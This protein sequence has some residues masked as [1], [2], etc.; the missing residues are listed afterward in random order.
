MLLLGAAAACSSDSGTKP[1]DYTSLAQLNAIWSV[2]G[3]LSFLCNGSPVNEDVTGT[4]IHVFN[5]AFNAVVVLPVATCGSDAIKFQGTIDLSGAITGNVST[6]G[7]SPLVDTFTGSCTS[8]SC[9]GATS[10]TALFSFTLSNT[11][12]DVYDG[13]SWQLGITCSDGS[14]MK[15]MPAVASIANAGVLQDSAK[16]CAGPICT[17]TGSTAGSG[18]TV[19][20]TGTVANDGTLSASFMQSAAETLTFAGATNTSYTSLAGTGT[21]G[22]AISLTQC[23]TTS[24]TGLP[25]CVGCIMTQ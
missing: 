17:A 16:T 20:L 8:S 12:E 2:T 19:T 9:T 3:H 14:A 15:L 1:P 24:G 10:N 21:F 25:L 18:E 4:G 5:G 13:T 22:A 23:S 7:A 6:T 11:H